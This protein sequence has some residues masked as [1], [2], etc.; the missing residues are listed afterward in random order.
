MYTELIKDELNLKEAVFGADLK[1]YITYNVKPQLKTLGPKYGRLLNGIRS[2]LAGADGLEI[3]SA[4]KNGNVYRFEVEGVKIE[5]TEE[6]LIVEPLQK[7][8]FCTETDGRVSVILDTALTP[9][10]IEEGFVREIIS[11]VQTMRKEAGFEVT[12]HITLCICDNA[13]LISIMRNNAQKIKKE[14][15]ADMLC[16]NCCAEGYKKD[17]SINGEEA[18]FCVAK[19]E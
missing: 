9:E 10:L 4:V 2:H 6:D 17:W 3:V 15:L 12:D 16:E 14:T 1:E 11:K 13:K 5:L 7:E 19:I 8:G 18:K